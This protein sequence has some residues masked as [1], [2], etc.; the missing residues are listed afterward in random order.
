MTKKKY[1]ISIVGYLN[2]LPFQYGIA[3][4]AIKERIELQLDMPA[5]CARK[6]KEGLVDIG[7][8]PVALLPKLKNHHLIS[9]YCI[10]AEGPV[11]SVKLYS[12]VPLTEIQTILLDYQSKTS[13]ALVQVLARQYWKIQ[14]DFVAAASGFEDQV[15]NK[16]AAVIIGDRTFSRNGTYPYEYDLANEWQKFTG[17]PFVFAAWVCT[18]LPDQE[19]LIAFNNALKYG[20]EHVD[21]AISAKNLNIKHFDPSDYLK[22]KISY[23]LTERKKQALDLFL[24]CL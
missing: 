21:E 12:P 13:V 17:L 10:G 4:S 8:V 20:V 1:S 5:E 19:F 14:P 2:T 22:N 15:K 7:L 3:Q 6:L 11:D 16:T 23:P 18:S 24:T 9:N